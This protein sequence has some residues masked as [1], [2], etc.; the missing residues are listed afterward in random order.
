[1]GFVCSGWLVVFWF[2]ALLWVFFPLK[3]KISSQ[4]SVKAAQPPKSVPELHFIHGPGH[5]GYHINI[6]AFSFHD[7]IYKE[8]WEKEEAEDQ[9]NAENSLSL[10][11]A[12]L[13]KLPCL[14]FLT[15]TFP[16]TPWPALAV[17]VIAKHCP[18]PAVLGQDPWKEHASLSEG[19]RNDLKVLFQPWGHKDNIKVIGSS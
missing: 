10:K 13:I 8:R 3:M 19:W 17:R 16:A 6:S 18:I 1:M 4:F 12:F 14:C 7:H 2:F 9:T 11:N 5:L 15:Y